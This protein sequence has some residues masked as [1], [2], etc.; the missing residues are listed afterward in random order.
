VFALPWWGQLGDTAALR[1]TAERADHLVAADKDS[2]NLF[3]RDAAL[4]YLDLARADTS[5][6]LRRFLGLSYDQNFQGIGDWERLTTMQVLNATKRYR[7][8]VDRSDREVR[9]TPLPFD[10]LVALERGRALEGLEH[11]ERA[12][13]AYAEVASTWLHADPSLQPR[14]EEARVALN[15]LRPAL[16][17]RASASTLA[18]DDQRSSTE[19]NAGSARPR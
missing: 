7:E 1:R 13:A 8:A 12:A 16:G 2:S 14:V 10:V 19:G 15:R 9:S 17:A 18:L 6:A 5:S 11:R 4:A 3:L